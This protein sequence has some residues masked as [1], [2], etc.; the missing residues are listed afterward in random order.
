MKYFKIVLF[1][2][3]MMKLLAE[4]KVTLTRDIEL[5]LVMETAARNATNLR[6]PVTLEVNKIQLQ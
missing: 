5:V 3:S 2:E 6:K 1:A 4:N